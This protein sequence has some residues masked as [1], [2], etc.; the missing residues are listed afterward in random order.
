MLFV[1]DIFWKISVYVVFAVYAVYV[2]KSI[3]KYFISVF[4]LI[5]DNHDY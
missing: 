2:L 3:I 4:I 5:Y 1:S